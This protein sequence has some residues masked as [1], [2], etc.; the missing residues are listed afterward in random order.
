[1][2]AGVVTRLEALDSAERCERQARDCRDEANRQALL[3]I[4]K[5]WRSLAEQQTAADRYLDQLMVGKRRSE[6]PAFR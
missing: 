3:S 6:G 1:M 5:M 2:E 4:A